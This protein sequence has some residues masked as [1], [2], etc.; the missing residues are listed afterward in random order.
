MLEP[1]ILEKVIVWLL[2]LGFVAFC[3]GYIYLVLVVLQRYSISFEIW[4]AV[5]ALGLIFLSLFGLK[6]FG[7]FFRVE[8]QD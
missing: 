2:L 6:L 4:I 1:K 7:R 5:L 3:G 8:K